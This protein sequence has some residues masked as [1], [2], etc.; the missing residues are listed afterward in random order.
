[1]FPGSASGTDNFWVDVQVS[2]TAPATYTGSWRLWPGF[3]LA[4]NMTN[5]DIAVNYAVGTEVRLNQPCAVN[6]IW[7]FSPVGTAQLATEA[8]VW[9]VNSGGLTGTKVAS[10]VSPTW[11]GAAGSGW[12][13]ATFSSPPTLAAG[14]Y[15]VSVYN[16]AATPDQWSAKRYGYWGTSAATVSAGVPATADPGVAGITSG[17]LYAPPSASASTC[18]SYAGSSNGNTLTEPGQCPFWQGPPNSFPQQY[19]GVN[20]PGGDLFQNYWVDVEVTPT[21]RTVAGAAGSLTFA[22]GVGYVTV[23]VVGQT[24]QLRYSAAAGRVDVT[25]VAGAAG[26]LACTAG[27]GTLSI[28]GGVAISGAA[29]QAGFMSAPG[30]VGITVPG[31]AGS[32]VWSAGAG[33]AATTTPGN[34][35]VAGAAGRSSFTAAS[36]TVSIAGNVIVIGV[37]GQL[38]AAAPAGATSIVGPFTVGRLTATTAALAA[39]EPADI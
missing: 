1:M 29:G 2:D 5:D 38:R 11:S 9:S 13:S 6:K 31:A 26:Q 8:D 32:A 14:T 7:Y 39:L 34:V 15:R 18:Y 25:I 33:T 27:A 35:V 12:I 21:S 37:A 24:G 4:D 22:A 19:V 20:T 17:P 23:P 10:L 28:S 3:Y 16:G 30:L 36:G